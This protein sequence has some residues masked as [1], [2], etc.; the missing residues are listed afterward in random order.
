MYYFS[1]NSIEDLK[2]FYKR[3]V[4]LK[5]FG[6]EAVSVIMMYGFNTHLSE[7]YAIL[8]MLRKL[9]LIPF[10]QQYQPIAGVSAMV[11]E[12]YFDF[13]LDQVIALTFR[14]NGQNGE[15]YLRWLSNH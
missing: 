2:K 4:L 5:G 15:K 13:D 1:C 3:S 14:T 6:R 11:P 8:L 12:N 9:G 7:E 10:V